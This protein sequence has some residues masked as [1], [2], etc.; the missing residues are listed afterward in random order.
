M[1]CTSVDLFGLTIN[2]MLL[3]SLCVSSYS[4]VNGTDFGPRSG[5]CSASN[6]LDGQVPSSSCS[7]T[8]SHVVN[9]DATPNSTPVHQASD[10]DTESRTGKCDH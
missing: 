7:P 3:N 1:Y 2:K 4:S 10:S 8:L 5:F 6:G 9:G